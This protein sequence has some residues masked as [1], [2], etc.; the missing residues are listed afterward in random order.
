MRIGGRLFEVVGTAPLMEAR[1]VR[2]VEADQW[3]RDSV[4]ETLIDPLINAPQ[5][6]RFV[7]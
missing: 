5:A 1:I 4:F 3:I 2:R 7:F 6:P